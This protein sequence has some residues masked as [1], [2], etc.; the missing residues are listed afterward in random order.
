MRPNK[1]RTLSRLACIAAGAIIAG[2][3]L[4]LRADTTPAEV[5]PPQCTSPEPGYCVQLA[6]LPAPEPWW[7]LVTV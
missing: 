4:A 3:V 6:P 5:H 1:A 7:G 2:T